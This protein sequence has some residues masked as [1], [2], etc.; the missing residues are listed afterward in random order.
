MKP[1]R[2]SS[3]AE[4]RRLGKAAAHVSSTLGELGI[5]LFTLEA[6]LPHQE[7]AQ[8]LGTQLESLGLAAAVDTAGPARVRSVMDGKFDDVDVL[9]V[10]GESGPDGEDQLMDLV[11]WLL[12]NGRTA[13]AQN[14]V[15]AQWGEGR[16]KHQPVFNHVVLQPSY[17]GGEQ[18]SGR[19]FPWAAS[20][21]DS[22]ALARAVLDYAV[23]LG[24]E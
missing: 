11:Q 5:L 15:F 2:T 18:Q 7:V 13:L 6:K 20:A 14:L 9:V 16:A 10:L 4:Q 1:A 8:R 19:R 12:A 23:G 17:L 21:D 22:W 24:A 3:R